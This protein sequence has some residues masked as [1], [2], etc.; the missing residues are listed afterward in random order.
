MLQGR[1]HIAFATVDLKR[2]KALYGGIL[3]CTEGRS[4]E[5]WVDYDFFGHQLT[6]QQVPRIKRAER[7]YNP[8]S[9]IPSDHFG[10]VLEWADWQRMRDKLRKVGVRF[11]VEPQLV[12]KGQ[13]GEQMSLFIEDPDGHAVEFKAFENARDLFRRS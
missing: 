12:M 7:T 11:L 3:G 4:A 8:Q 10:I 1:F 5:N 13:V 9:N 2:M 6:I